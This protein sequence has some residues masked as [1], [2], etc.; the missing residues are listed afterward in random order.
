M[1]DTGGEA[2][3]GRVLACVHN[4]SREKSHQ[5]WVCQTGALLQ[6]VDNTHKPS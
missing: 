3:P 6:H 1:S 4:S 2:V 5:V